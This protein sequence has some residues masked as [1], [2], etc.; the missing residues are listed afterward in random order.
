MAGYAPLGAAGLLEPPRASLTHPP[1]A[2]TANKKP[3]AVSRIASRV[4]PGC[5]R[6]KMPISGQPEIGAHFVSFNF[7]NSTIWALESRVACGAQ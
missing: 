5:A 1:A 4:H 2:I 3:G 6:M 7:A